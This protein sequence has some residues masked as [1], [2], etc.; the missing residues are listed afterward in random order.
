MKLARTA[1]AIIWRTVVCAGAALTAPACGGTSPP[2]G[3]PG[4]MGEPPDAAVDEPTEVV[5]V[6]P[7]AAP[8]PV[9]P[10]EPV[11]PVDPVEE[12]VDPPP[13]VAPEMIAIKV[14]SKPSGATVYVDGVRAGK[15]PVEIQVPRDAKAELRVEKSGYNTK[16][17]EVAGDQP[18]ELKVTLKKKPKVKEPRPRGPGEGGTGRG[19]ILS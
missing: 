19:F 17:L 2:A 4:P 8:A 3:T 18:E 9:D 12:P 6:A 11:D 15:T 16:T 7:D 5:V 13:E 10:V 1:T 14:T